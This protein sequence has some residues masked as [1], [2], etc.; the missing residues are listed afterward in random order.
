MEP[1]IKRFRVSTTPESSGNLLEVEI[2]LET[3]EISWNLVD[4]A[5]EIYN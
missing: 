2:A 5:G 1:R 4:A 3:L